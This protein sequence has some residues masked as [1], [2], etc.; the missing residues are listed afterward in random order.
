MEQRKVEQGQMF[1]IRDPD[2]PPL[3]EEEQRLEAERVDAWLEGALLLQRTRQSKAGS[4][5]RR[6]AELDREEI[7]TL[8][9]QL[10]AEGVPRHKRAGLISSKLHM[11]RR[12]VDNHLH[13]LRSRNESEK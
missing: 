10:A 11:N 4:H 12:T 13:T 5:S 9:N 8:Y 3:S 2:L 7:K 6:D 1:F